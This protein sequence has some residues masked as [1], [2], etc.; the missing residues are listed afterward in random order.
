MLRFTIKR[1]RRRRRRRRREEEEEDD[2]EDDDDHD[3]VFSLDR[4]DENYATPSACSSCQLLPLRLLSSTTTLKPEGQSS[5]ER[6]AAIKSKP[7]R[8]S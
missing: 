2:D 5:S 7:A 6:A 3:C 8:T 1:S 4:D